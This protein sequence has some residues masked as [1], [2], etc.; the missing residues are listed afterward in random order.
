MGTIGLKL[1]RVGID[2]YF[3]KLNVTIV[4]VSSDVHSADSGI[5]IAYWFNFGMSYDGDAVA[6]APPRY[7]CHTNKH[8]AKEF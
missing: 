7:Y 5:T 2:S 6:W 1:I 3:K 4:F 8:H